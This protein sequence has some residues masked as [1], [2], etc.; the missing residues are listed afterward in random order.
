M[1]EYIA[2]IRSRYGDFNYE[3]P[4]TAF[5]PEKIVEYLERMI[6]EQLNSASDASEMD[7]DLRPNSSPKKNKSRK[8][9]SKTAVLNGPPAKTR[10]NETEFGKISKSMAQGLQSLNQVNE[11]NIQKNEELKK[12]LDKI[13]GEKMALQQTHRIEVQRLEEEKNVLKK[14]LDDAEMAKREAEKGFD[15]VKMELMAQIIALANEKKALEQRIA[16]FEL[17]KNKNICAH[18]QSFVNSLAF[19]N[20]DCAE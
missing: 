11:Q 15:D 1:D 2:F 10:C 14:K 3:E 12:D 4:Q 19:C 9:T 13:T 7:S 18:C 5:V 16:A 20:N 17:N 8:R 6:G